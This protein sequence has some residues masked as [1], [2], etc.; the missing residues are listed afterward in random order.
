MSSNNKDSSK[1][2]PMDF[3]TLAIGTAFAFAVA[4][5]SYLYYKHHPIIKLTQEQA[6]QFANKTVVITGAN[7]GIGKQ[8]FF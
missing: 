7:S 8:I 3:S 4:G 1:G 6:A 5:G 2:F